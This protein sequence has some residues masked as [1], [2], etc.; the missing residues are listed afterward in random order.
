[1]AWFKRHGVSVMKP[2]PPQNVDLNPIAHLWNEIK[3]Q[4][5]KTPCKNKEELKQAFSSLAQCNRNI[6]C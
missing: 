5:E 1:M 3:E 6:Y 2:W 4:L